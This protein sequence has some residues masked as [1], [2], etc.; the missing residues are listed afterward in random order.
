M[1]ESK[2]ANTPRRKRMWRDVEK[3]VLSRGGSPAS[4]AKQANAVVKRDV[5]KD[6]RRAKG[7]K[8]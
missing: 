3:S 5:A 1:P 7:K 4:A 8:K 2:K 6:K